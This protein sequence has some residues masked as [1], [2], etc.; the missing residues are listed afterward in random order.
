M[1]GARLWWISGAAWQSKCVPQFYEDL[2]LV[3]SFMP[4]SSEFGVPN[5]GQSFADALAEKDKDANGA[6]D[7]EEWQH[8][9]MQQTWF[10]WDLDGDNR[11]NARE[12]EYLQSTQ[13]AKGGLFAIDLEVEGAPRRGDVTATHMAWQYDGRRGLSDVVTPLLVG[14]TVYVLE[15]GGLLTALDARTGEVGKQARVGEPDDYFAS[16]VAA[17]DR[18]LTASLSG[19]LAVIACGAEWEVVS[20]AKV[21]GKVWATP[22][23]A[24]G[25]LFVRAESQL[26]CFTTAEMPATESDSEAAGKGGGD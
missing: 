15:D 1:T 2:C 26:S 10:I 7:R 22:A 16:P 4:P 23:L 5:L 11:L 17:G 13:T 18:L 19:Q 12:Y 20:T 14:G 6:I 8:D 3:S 24:D 21:E 9:V 25:R